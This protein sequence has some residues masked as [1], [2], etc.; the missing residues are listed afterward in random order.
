MNTSN[1]NGRQESAL[2][3]LSPLNVWALSFGCLIGWG[4]FVM[5]GTMFLPHAGP[6][7]TI[8]AMCLGALIMLAI[9]ANFSFLGQRYQDNGGIFTFTR[10]LLGSD[11]AFLAAWSLGLA[12]LS[13]LWANATA[14]V[15]LARYFLGDVLEWGFHYQVLGFDIYFGEILA[16]WLILIAFGLFACYGGRVR[17]YVH[18]ALA[19]LLFFIVT[20]LFLGVDINTHHMVFTPAFQEGTNPALQVFSML[21]LAPWMFFGF[22]AVT[23]AQANFTFHPRKLYLITAVSVISGAAVYCMLTAGAVLSVPD[24]FDRWDDYIASLQHMEGLQ[25]LPVFNSVMSIYGSWGAYLMGVA[26]FAALA[27]SLLGFYRA[28]AFLFH[29]MPRDKLL[30]EKY[31]QEDEHGLPQKATLLVLFLSLPVPLL[32]RN[33]IA[34]L[35]DV[36]TISGSVAYAYVSL[37]A[38]R[39]ARQDALLWEGFL[40][41]V[42]LAFSLFF[43]F[44]P[45][46]PNMLLGSGLDTESYLLL[47]GWSMSGFIYYWYVFK[48]DKTNHFGSSTIMCVMLL[49]LTFFSTSM[50][51]RQVTEERLIAAAQQGVTASHSALSFTSIAQ[52]LFIMLTLF[53][54]FDIFTTIRGREENLDQQILDDHTL[55]VVK[56]TYLA[57]VAHDIRLLTNSFID[58]VQLSLETCAICLVCPE[59]KAR[60]D[61]PEAMGGHLSRIEPLNHYLLSLIYSML[62]VN[63]MDEGTITLKE[64]PMDLNRTMQQIRDVFSVLMTERGVSYKVEQLIEDNNVLC[65]DERL[66]RMLMNLV[67][68]AY[69][70]TS[71]GDSVSI[72]LRQKGPAYRT[73]HGKWHRR[74]ICADYEL[75]VKDTGAAFQPEI[76]HRIRELFSGA[77]KADFAA[78][79]DLGRGL[80]IVKTIV[81]RMEGTIELARTGDTGKEFIVNL[82]LPLAREYDEG[83]EEHQDA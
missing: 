70:T 40:G 61:L 47:A 7:G 81:D 14:F 6:I 13:L 45:I 83:K 35:T 25:A 50:W 58:Y 69:S 16:T 62:K 66:T 33:A 43:F 73:T 76:A 59:P 1:G 68:N 18:V 15:L 55:S 5:P 52:M 34:W 32:G 72:L 65:D 22:E 21:M 78:L 36:T 56:N 4:A 75:R 49:F 48:R 12:Y 23:H 54:M 30:P 46:L 31:A 9:G 77:Q 39:A 82:T 26:V 27:T 37:C 60:P 38:Y 28:C 10:M 42:G 71:Q 2:R 11:H 64:I 74:T 67:G 44:C 8:I 63:S 20:G 17:R 79:K 29:S 19:L 53:L 3:F 80:S 24:G 41:L 57:N 51:M